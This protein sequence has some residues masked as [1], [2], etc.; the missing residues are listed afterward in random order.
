MKKG[1]GLIFA[2]ALACGGGGNL[3]TAMNG[4]WA[5]PATLTISGESPQSF[6]G[7]I[8]VAVSGDTATFSGICLD[9]S[10]SVTA[11][12]SGNSASWS[13]SFPCPAAPFTGCSSVVLT[14][15]S[16]SATL[17]GSTMN[18]QGGGNAAGCGIS[19]GFTLSI[20]GTK[21]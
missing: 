13:G 21:Q 16:A 3:N 8:Q 12:G 10:G 14:L 2:S 1:L 17:N 19:K 11:H 5:G 6:T 20:A 7:S 15:Q 9:G 18:A 4:T